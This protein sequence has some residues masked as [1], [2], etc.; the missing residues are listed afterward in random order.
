MS[1]FCTIMVLGNSI[2]LFDMFL[3][4]VLLVLGCV[5]FVTGDGYDMRNDVIAS[6]KGKC[7]ENK[8]RNMNNKKIEENVSTVEG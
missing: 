7:D 1:T 6:I 3:G 4:F 5:F 2:G 8:E